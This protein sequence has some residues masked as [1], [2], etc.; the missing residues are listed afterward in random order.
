VSS[1]LTLTSRRLPAHL[2]IARSICF[3]A[4]LTI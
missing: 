1:H 4:R 3:P 2:A